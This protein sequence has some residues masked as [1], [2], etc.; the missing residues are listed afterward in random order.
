MTFYVEF[1]WRGKKDS[2]QLTGDSWQSVRA[3]LMIWYPGLSILV[4]REV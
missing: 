1:R 3:Q 2:I 4:C